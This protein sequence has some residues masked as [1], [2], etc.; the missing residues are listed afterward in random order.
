MCDP[1]LGNRGELEYR[2]RVVP[3][4]PVLPAVVACCELVLEAAVP[5]FVVVAELVAIQQVT[6]V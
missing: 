2:V 3:S 6:V 4:A 1:I 5:D